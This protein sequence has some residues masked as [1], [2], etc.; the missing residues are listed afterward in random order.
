LDDAFAQ[1]LRDRFDPIR[2]DGR[3]NPAIWL[4]NRLDAHAWSKQLEIMQSVQDHQRT[5]VPSCHGV[6]K[7]QVA[8]WA[9]ARF[10]DVHD[11]G[12]AMV[13]TTAPRAHQ[14]RAILWRYVRRIHRKAGLPGTITQG[15]VPEWHIDGDLVGFG[16]K[17][18]DLDADTFQGVHEYRLLIVF[19]EACGIREDLFTAAESLMTNEGCHW[20]CIGNPDDRS[21]FFHKVCTTEPDWHVIPIS[22]YQSPNLTGEPV[23]PDVAE[24]LVSKAWVDD[25]RLRWGEASALFAAKVRGEWADNEDGLI[26][27]S[28]ATAAVRRWH[29]WKETGA[30]DTTIPGR[31]VI[32]VDPA[33]LGSDQ[34]AIAVR[35]GPV[36]L[37]VKRYAKLDTSQ[38]TSVVMAELGRWVDAVAVVDVG[39]VGAGVVDQLRHAGANVIAFNGANTSHQRDKSGQWRF[40]NCRSAS[41]HRLRELLDPA[42]GEQVCIPDDDQLVADL[43][44]PTYKPGISNTLV[45]ERKDAVKARIGRSPDS[46][47]ALA[48]CFWT[49]PPGRR[50][51]T[52]DPL[53]DT[54]RPL[55]P[56][57][58]RMAD[59]QNWEGF[60]APAGYRRGC[61]S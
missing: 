59:Y 15:Q 17:P 23:P 27:L 35:K 49:D 40:P 38:L 60:T 24:R 57:P 20:L 32:G 2:E 52:S 25:K 45:V 14:V 44:A 43:T 54:D 53:D 4:E 12:T 61:W 7:S 30:A 51:S 18:A 39:G 16:R 41:W 1:S 13:I 28:W 19:D 56:M 8:A 34:S 37:S 9:I 6:G 47:D 33:W 55:T 11:P 31:T 22:A 42:H 50:L 46:G 48:Y 36:V 58:Y 10:I 3:T 26:P 29:Q 21:S 5:A